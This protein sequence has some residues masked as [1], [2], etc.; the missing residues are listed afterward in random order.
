MAP[1]IRR[2]SYELIHPLEAKRPFHLYNKGTPLLEHLRNRIDQWSEKALVD[3][4]LQV[5]A[6]QA[7]ALS[8]Q[9]LLVKRLLDM[10]P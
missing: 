10:N 8:I 5:G 7:E 6:L 3:C 4:L 9:Q 1:R 2:A